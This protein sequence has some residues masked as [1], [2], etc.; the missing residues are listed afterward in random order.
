MVDMVDNQAIKLAQAAQAQAIDL[1]ARIRLQR[2][3]SQ[4]SWAESE[5][6]DTA[7][8]KWERLQPA[9]Q[10]DSDDQADKDSIEFS[11]G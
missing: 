6:I 5:I 11:S 1:A 4:S 2:L 8:Q 7:I 10:N 3:Q 9:N